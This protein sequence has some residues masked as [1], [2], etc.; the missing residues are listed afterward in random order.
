MTDSTTPKPA[1]EAKPKAKPEAAPKAAPDPATGGLFDLGPKKPDPA[2]AT[3]KSGNAVADKAKEAREKAEQARKEEEE[4]VYS[5][6][7]EVK[8]VNHLGREEIRLPE[9]MK[10]AEVIAHLSDDYPEVTSAGAKFRYD[11]E[12]DRIVLTLGS[13]DKG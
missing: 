6:G 8:Y 9:P 3:T 2:K 12:K 10:K 4:R 1:A 5:A 13:F 7:T 11:K